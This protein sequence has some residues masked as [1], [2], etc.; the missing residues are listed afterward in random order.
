MVTTEEMWAWR[1]KDNVRIT[2]SEGGSY[3]G[4]VIEILEEEEVF[5]EDLLVLQ[6]GEKS[7][8]VFRKEEIIHIETDDGGQ[9]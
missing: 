8:K 5:G 9:E 6:I 4:S 7:I 2:N 1:Y 3:I